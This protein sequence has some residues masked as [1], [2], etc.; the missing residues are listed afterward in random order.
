VTAIRRRIHRRAEAAFT[1]ARSHA[2]ADHVAEAYGSALA[3]CGW[4]ALLLILGGPP[5]ETP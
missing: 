4:A 2:G 3:G 1:R 5:K